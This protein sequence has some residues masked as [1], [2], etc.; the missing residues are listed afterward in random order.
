MMK[1]LF[2][3]LLNLSLSA[4]YLVPIV[5]VLRLVLK[6]APRWTVCL[7]WGLVALRLVMPF[8]L[9][10]DVSLHP[11]REPIADLQTQWGGDTQPDT[12]PEVQPEP[13]PE[14]PS[15]TP[16]PTPAEK[17][18]DLMEILA[19]GWL[20]GACTMALYGAVSYVRLKLKVRPSLQVEK[21][22][23]VCDGI[24]YP[25]LLGVL[26]PKVYLPSNLQEP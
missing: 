19:W 21:R 2:T 4:A 26:R 18:L 24:G 10:S 13:L 11:G 8:S 15:V 7:L 25:F 23:F 14:A 12:L 20:A 5:L 1:E 16:A 6:K 3:E 9:E 17:E 22:V